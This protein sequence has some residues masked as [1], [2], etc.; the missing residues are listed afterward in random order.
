ML[1]VRC[2]SCQMVF[3]TNATSKHSNV[4]CPGCNAVH[5]LG[6]LP[7]STAGDSMLIHPGALKQMLESPRGPDA[8]RAHVRNE[9]VIYCPS[10][11]VRLHINR[12]KYGGRRVAC[13]ECRKPMLVPRVTQDPSE[14]ESAPD[15]PNLP[16]N[17]D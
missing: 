5:A 13:P 12:K 3:N 17:N 16:S 8:A 7:T 6:S 2:L 1:T 4:Q 11:K 9:P 14:V 10:C 15:E